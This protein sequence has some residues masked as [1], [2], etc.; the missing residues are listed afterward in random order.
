MTDSPQILQEFTQNIL[1]DLESGAISVHEAYAAASQYAY[2]RQELSSASLALSEAAT[3]GDEELTQA[4]ARV[5]AQTLTKLSELPSFQSQQPDIPETEQDIRAVASLQQTATN[6]V[7]EQIKTPGAKE[8]RRAFVHNLV[9]RFS[10]TIPVT[11]TQVESFFDK[12]AATASYGSTPNQQTDR[13]AQY[14]TNS[15]ENISGDLSLEQK[16]VIESGILAATTEQRE[17]LIDQFK[18]T[19]KE[20]EIYS[21]LF[22]TPDIKRPDVFVDVILNAPSLEPTRESL[23]RAEKLARVAQS[24]E[25]SSGKHGGKLQFFSAN[26]AKGIAGGIQKGAD[27]ILSLVGE[28][29]RDMVLH[30]KVHGSL[31]SMLSNTQQFADRLGENFV[32]SAFFVHINQDLTKQLSDKTRGGQAGSM[33]GDV[34]STVFRG[35]LGQPLTQSTKEGILDYFELARAN[36]AAPKGKAFL[37]QGMFPWN[38]YRTYENNSLR[39]DGYSRNKIGGFFPTLGFGAI[40]SFFGDLFSSLID[41]TTSFALLNP[42]LPGQLS[43]SRRAAAMPTKIID[44]MPLFVALVVVIVLVLLFVFP[45]PLNL[46]MISHSSKVSAL[47][48]ALKNNNGSGGGS[49]PIGTIEEATQTCANIAGVHAY[50]TDSSWANINCQ[51]TRPDAPA[52]RP[53]TECTIGLS[54]CGS[55]STA[56]ILNSFGSNTTVPTVWGVQHQQGGYAY[57]N[58][59]CASYWSGPINILRD[60]GLSVFQVSINEATEV[61]KN[62]GLLLAFVDEKWRTGQPTGH[63][64]VITGLSQERGSIKATTLD[65][66]REPGY[67]STVTSNPTN[68]GDIS[69]N[70]LFAV[71]K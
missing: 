40:G 64:I 2:L 38:I 4:F 46:N 54:G 27:G 5:I 6:R 63:V 22:N 59:S 50:Q 35:P 45:S 17:L 26:G 29:V 24:L 13:F 20:S 36:A 8:K 57:Y 51:G 52:C 41:K 37:A 53:P 49:F 32:R 15:I 16:R 12:A 71:V 65:P 43:A 31:R 44:D 69:I 68:P 55:T 25:E 48:D 33:F 60:A 23:T 18:Q 39:G 9:D 3:V 66:L 21:A 1:T 7:R 14:L 70:G 30:E 11:D 47:L 62:C 56:M 34:F 58:G 10:S 42:R 61:L 28:P 19:Q 67:T